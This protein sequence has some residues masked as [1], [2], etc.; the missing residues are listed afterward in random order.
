MGWVGAVFN[1]GA[2][3]VGSWFLVPGSWSVRGP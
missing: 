3:A 2:G 1:T